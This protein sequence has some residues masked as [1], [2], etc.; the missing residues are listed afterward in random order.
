MCVLQVAVKIQHPN[1]A[2]RLGIDMA[3]LMRAADAVGSVKGVQVND[4]VAQFASNFYMQLDFRDEAENLRRFRRHFASGF[5]RAI[6]SFPTPVDDLVSQHVV[7]E[8]FEK[9]ESV[10][11]YLHK[12]GDSPK[13]TKWRREGTK[14]VPV[15]PS[16]ALENNVKDGDDL[17]LRKKVALCGVQSYLKM[18]MMDNFIH[19]DLHP[20][21]VLVRMEEADWIARLQRWLLI[22]QTGA[23][24]PHIVFL[25]AGLA[26]SFNTTIYSNVQGFFESIIKFDG[27]T[28]GKAILG[29]AP[30]QP[31]VK[32]P[33]TFIEEVTAKMGEQ[34]EEMLNGEGRAGDNIRAYMASV[35]AHN[36]KLD[37]TVMVA[38]MSMLV[39][40]G[41]QFRLDPSTSIVGAIETQLDRRSSLAG[42]LIS[43]AR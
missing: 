9:G 12:A 25:D 3:I 33:Q 14:W 2:E 23:R 8:T 1:L 40:E 19:A 34:R 30:T 27:P 32:S 10:A 38:L 15:D 21:N 7:V 29:L 36:V 37:P 35:R 6:V 39:L 22:G 17:E 4:T 5:W 26:A 42:W 18:L 13:V 43:F 11:E 31:Y 20:G 24:V 28:F 16:L 41:W